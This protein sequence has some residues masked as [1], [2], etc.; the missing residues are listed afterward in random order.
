MSGTCKRRATPP[1]GMH[2]RPNANELRRHDTL[3]ASG[4][5]GRM[6]SS[7]CGERRLHRRGPR[8]L[9][10]LARVGAAWR[11]TEKSFGQQAANRRFERGGVHPAEALRLCLGEPQAWH[12]EVL[13][14]NAVERRIIRILRHAVRRGVLRPIRLSARSHRRSH[15]RPVRTSCEKTGVRHRVENRVAYWRV[16]SRKLRPVRHRP[17]SARHFEKHAVQPV[18]IVIAARPLGSIRKLASWC[19]GLGRLS[20]GAPIL[21]PRARAR[22]TELHTESDG[23]CGAVR[24]DRNTNSG[25]TRL[26]TRIHASK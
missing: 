9:S 14:S 25:K 3:A 10:L 7:V 1:A 21:V 5:L 13:A 18:P 20:H 22:C 6:P 4:P 16:H 26:S 24:T 17:F 19:V 15:E 11:A 2:R 23:A 12:L 8:P